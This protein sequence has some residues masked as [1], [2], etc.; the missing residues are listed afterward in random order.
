VAINK[1]MQVLP[2]SAREGIGRLLKADK[3]LADA[4]QSQ[5]AAY[6]ERASRSE[7]G[8]EQDSPQ[9]SETAKR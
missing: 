8:L 5:R 2:R 3:V 7:P 6:E 9:P 4:N 1:L